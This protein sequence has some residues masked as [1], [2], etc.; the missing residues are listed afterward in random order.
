MHSFGFLL[1]PLLLLFSLYFNLFSLMAGNPM[2]I[3]IYL[4]SFLSFVSFCW[5]FKLFV[6]LYSCFSFAFALQPWLSYFWFALPMVVVAN[7]NMRWICM[8]YSISPGNGVI[9]TNPLSVHCGNSVKCPCIDQK[10]KW[11][12]KRI[13]YFYWKW[14]DLR[15]YCFS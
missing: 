15:I 1:L 9:C 12:Q 14:N 4:P 13:C 5:M 6:L 10:L 8:T 11:W 3:R 7:C 2:Y